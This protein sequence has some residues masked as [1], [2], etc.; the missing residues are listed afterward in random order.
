MLCLIYYGGNDMNKEELYDTPGMLEL[1]LIMQN[2]MREEFIIVKHDIQH[3]K[4]ISGNMD[5]EGFKE[6]QGYAETLENLVE[7][8]QKH[9]WEVFTSYFKEENK[10]RSVQH[11]ELT[12]QSTVYRF[13]NLRVS[14]MKTLDLISNE[15]DF[16][17]KTIAEHLYS[18]P[19]MIDPIRRYKRKIDKD[20]LTVLMNILQSYSAHFNKLLEPF[21]N[22]DNKKTTDKLSGNKP[23][24]IFV[25]YS[26]STKLSNAKLD[27]KIYNILNLQDEESSKVDSSLTGFIKLPY[28]AIKITEYTSAIAH[29]IVHLY[30]HQAKNEN[31]LKFLKDDLYDALARTS[32]KNGHGH[33]LPSTWSCAL[34]SFTEELLVDLIAFFVAGPAYYFTLFM[35]GTARYPGHYNIIRKS[36]LMYAR[37]MVL[38]QVFKDL[39]QKSNLKISEEFI[40]EVNNQEYKERPQNPAKIELKYKKDLE[41]LGIKNH[42]NNLIEEIESNNVFVINKMLYAAE[43]YINYILNEHKK[44]ANGNEKTKSEARSFTLL[45]KDIL[46]R[47]IADKIL[48]FLHNSLFINDEIRKK[49][50]KM[51]LQKIKKETNKENKEKYALLSNT[52]L[53]SKFYYRLLKDYSL[54]LIT[55]NSNQKL[56]T[57]EGQKF[58]NILMNLE[59]ILTTFNNNKDNEEDKQIKLQNSV[60]GH[61]IKKDNNHPNNKPDKYEYYYLIPEYLWENTLMNINLFVLNQKNIANKNSNAKEHSSVDALWYDTRLPKLQIA[62]ILA[63][64]ERRDLFSIEN[65]NSKNKE[66]LIITGIKEWL[67]TKVD[68]KT[69]YEKSK[70]MV[71]ADTLKEYEELLDELLKLNSKEEIEKSLAEKANKLNSLTQ[72]INAFVESKPTLIVT[73]EEK[74]ELCGL[75][76]NVISKSD[77]LIEK[78]KDQ[79]KNKDAILKIKKKFKSICIAD[80]LKE[81]EELLDELLK[82]NSKEEIEKSLAEKANKLNSLTQD[83]NA[84]V[85]SKPTLIVT[86][87]EK[88]E[89]C[90]LIN[91]V[92]SKSDKLTKKIEATDNNKDI[93]LKTR[94]KLKKIQPE[95]CVKNFNTNIVQTFNHLIKEKMSQDGAN[96]KT[97]FVLGDYDFI[98]ELDEASTRKDINW[99]PAVYN[100]NNKELITNYSYREYIVEKIE[101]GN[102]SNV[103]KGGE[104]DGSKVKKEENEKGD[105]SDAKKDEKEPYILQFIKFKTKNDDNLDKKWLKHLIFKLLKDGFEVYLSNS[106]NIIFVKIPITKFHNGKDVLSKKD[107]ESEFLAMFENI[108]QDSDYIEDIQSYIVLPCADDLNCECIKDIDINIL[109]MK[110]IVKTSGAI[111]SKTEYTETKI[112]NVI[113][114]IK[115]DVSSIKKDEAYFTLG[116]IDYIINWGGIKLCNAI[117]IAILLINRLTSLEYKHISTLTSI[118]VLDSNKDSDSTKQKR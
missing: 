96:I 81:Y 1:M 114:S 41:K 101:L 73:N 93:I 117:K 30:L 98:I 83:I 66:N 49:R 111:E 68:W 100:D 75:I 28:W 59:N 8:S 24:L 85:E 116:I 20:E 50:I 35:Q 62:R 21:K 113:K 31:T 97:G 58:Y 52:T 107:F 103:K 12:L 43:K 11:R 118:S 70:I 47:S 102:Q 2:T 79:N 82:L 16:L 71:I 42:G 74:K 6:I 39:L 94:E 115:N 80:T 95:L 87:E 106:W 54:R 91:N 5:Q 4:F 45:Q 64:K 32:S 53:K 18:L 44:I 34:H 7:K 109:N 56:Y 40:K 72:D 89:L 90:G 61:T 86:N 19:P 22:A 29:E 51:L 17:H 88:K 33:G 15:L 69:T 84:F 38:T 108:N 60:I 104:E 9:L 99:P 78:I 46:E 110:S 23:P 112:K 26:A 67:F 76:N 3:L 10:D 63:I 55:Q 77:E 25:D 92:I 14:Y 65:N 48:G 27:K 13:N 37:I 36:T 105:Q 57:G